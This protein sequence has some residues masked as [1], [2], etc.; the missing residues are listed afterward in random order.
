MDRI[1]PLQQFFNQ[2]NSVLPRKPDMVDTDFNGLNRNA[3]KE[4]I[5]TMDI[6]SMHEHDLAIFIKNNIDEICED[7]LNGTI[8]YIGLFNDMNFVNAL[9]RAVSSIPIDPKYRLAL[10]KLAYDYFT[11]DDSVYQIKQKYLSISRVVNKSEINKLLGLGFLDENTAANLVLSRYSSTNEKTNV[12][13]LNFVLY[14]KDPNIMTEQ[15]VVWIYE[16]LFDRIT[17]LFNATMFEAYS[18]QEEADFGESFMENYSTVTSVV[19]DFLNNMTSEN[20]TKI[21]RGYYEDWMFRNKPPIRCSLR[22]L[23]ADYSRIS[24]VVKYLDSIDIYIP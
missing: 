24:N 4:A 17:D 12:K 20:I 21:L 23:C 16:K 13:R 5:A 2:A 6:R 8:P 1:Y 19:L 11:S 22:S 10:N 7:I 3:F 18:K 15:N 14:Y 9:F